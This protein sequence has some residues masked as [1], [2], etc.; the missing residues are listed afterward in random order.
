M[1]RVPPTTARLNE[2]VRGSSCQSCRPRCKRGSRNHR[3]LVQQECHVDRRAELVAT[4]AAVARGEFGGLRDRTSP[5]CSFEYVYSASVSCGTGVVQRRPYHNHVVGTVLYSHRHGSP[6][7]V[8]GKAVRGEQLRVLVQHPAPTASGANKDIGR[9]AATV[10]ARDSDHDSISRHGDGGAKTVASDSIRGSQHGHLSEVR[11]HTARG[12]EHVRLALI[13]VACQVFIRRAHNQS[14][15]GD[16]DCEAE[17]VSRT[18]VRGRHLDALDQRVDDDQVVRVPVIHPNL[19]L[20]FR[21]VPLH[22]QAT[23]SSVP[24]RK[25][26]VTHD[27][28]APRVGKGQFSCRCLRLQVYRFDADAQDQGLRAQCEGVH[29]KRFAD[30]KPVLQSKRSILVPLYNPRTFVRGFEP[31]PREAKGSGGAGL[32]PVACSPSARQLEAQGLSRAQLHDRALRSEAHGK[33]LV[34]IAGPRSVGAAAHVVLVV[35]VA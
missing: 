29:A 2:H 26:A 25:L 15:G 20:P 32:H 31:I 5:A 28:F 12:H 4:A 10:V 23:P 9:T 16:R 8:V 33:A 7:G 27:G 34:P 17:K 18:P 6:K 30:R 19:Q 11:P 3:A 14:V 1:A 21:K 13:R 24:G 35:C 22:R